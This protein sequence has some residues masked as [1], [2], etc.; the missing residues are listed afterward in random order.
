MSIHETA[1][2]VGRH[3]VPAWVMQKVQ[4]YLPERHVINPTYLA[5]VYDPN[6]HLEKASKVEV[7]IC[8]FEERRGKAV[9]RRLYLSYGS[10]GTN[11]HLSCRNAHWVFSC[12]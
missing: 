1:H 9:Q 5:E 4:A 6:L 8:R 7:I 11:N 10:G 12:A 3:D 2:I